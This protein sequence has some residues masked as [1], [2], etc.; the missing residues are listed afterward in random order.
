M[1]YVLFFMILFNS[2][3]CAKNPYSQFYQDLTGDIDITKSSKVILSKEEPTMTFGTGVANI[4]EDTRRMLEKGY[5][6][7]GYSSFNAG[8]VTKDQAISHAKKVHAERVVVY[9]EYTETQSGTM[10]LAL[11][12]IQNSTTSFS[13]NI[14]GSGGYGS[15]SG[16][17]TTTTYGSR[18][19]YMPYHVM[20][21]DYFATYWVKSKPASFGVHVRNLTNEQKQD[22]RS[23]KGISVIA[24]IQ[25]SPAFNADILV[26]DIITRVGTYATDNVDSFSTAVKKQEGEKVTVT[27]LRNNRKINKIMT[28]RQHQHTDNGCQ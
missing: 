26:G 5:L 20:R 7:I 23:N 4:E 1:K 19:V 9:S 25:N 3:A 2:T 13:G 8:N 27:L 16:S 21:Y 22:I 11:P 12:D 14:S 15:Y 10:P 28:L 24:V 6:L 17:A 18:T